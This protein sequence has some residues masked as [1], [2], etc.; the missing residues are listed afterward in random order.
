MSSAIIPLSYDDNGNASNFVNDAAEYL[1]EGSNES[2]GPVILT[3]FYKISIC[4]SIPWLAF[5]GFTITF[6]AL[7]SKTWRVN[8]FFKS[9]NTHD[10]IRVSEKDVL[11]P[12]I[13]L[14][15]CNIIVLICWTMLNPLIY[16]RQYNNGTDLWNRD[17]SSIGICRSSSESD[18]GNSGAISYLIPLGISKYN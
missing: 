11:G 7:F 12:F 16:K 14:L 1:D 8:Q 2:T 18:G 15:S 4:M 13:L 9:K 10:R 3:D 6:S 17:I 5:I